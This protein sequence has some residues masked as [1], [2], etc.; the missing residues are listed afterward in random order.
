MLTTTDRPT[1]DPPLPAWVDGLRAVQPAAV[2]AIVEAFDEVDLV[3]LDAPVGSGKTLI[4]ELVRRELTRF[5]APHV[6]DILPRRSMYI[7]SD[8]GL[9]DQVSRDFTYSRV[10]KGRANYPTEHRRDLTTDACTQVKPTDECKWCDTCPYQVAK[11]EAM[12]SRFAVLNTAMFLTV[13]N[14]AR[15]FRDV[16]DGGF[17]PN[18]LVIADECDLLEDALI[19]FVEYEVPEWALE[20]CGRVDVPVKGAHKPTLLTWLRDLHEDLKYVWDHGREGM[21]PKRQRTLEGLMTATI[22][23]I[24]VLAA[25]IEGGDSGE[26]SGHWFRD[27]ET[28]TF[29]MRPVTVAQ[30]GGPYLWRHGSKWLLMSGTIVSAN[31]LV[32]SLGWDKPYRVVSVPNTFPAENRPIYLAPI[33]DMTYRKA[34]LERERLVYAIEQ[35]ANHRGRILVHTVSYRLAQYLHQTCEFGPG[36]P[37][38]TH[39]NARGKDM[40]LRRYLGTENAILFSPSMMRGVDLAGDKCRVQIIAK[41]PFPSLGDKQVSLRLHLPGGQLWYTVKTVRDVMQMVG[42]GVRSEDDWCDTYILD[43]Q[44]TRNIWSKW[45]ALFL[46]SFTEVVKANQDVRWLIQGLG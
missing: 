5:G 30:Y 42:R 10:L 24:G 21:D 45:R 38:I 26:E 32:E 39:D 40:A 25:D 15:F 2:N 20:M 6:T 19:G 41:A 36:R 7:C 8:K 11:V 18:G 35:I 33:A 44:F 43:Q 17:G 3:I 9:Q 28:S 27:Y 37:K 12:Q 14:H 34:D 4:A 22:R 16:E 29:K 23:V 1:Y 13:A 46:P 31:E